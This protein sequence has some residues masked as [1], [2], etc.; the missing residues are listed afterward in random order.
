MYVLRMYT[1]TPSL[2]KGEEGNLRT[3]TTFG[4]DSSVEMFDTRLDWPVVK[5][6]LAL[7]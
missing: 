3:W 4:D 2:H 7:E 5:E 1:V 6:Q